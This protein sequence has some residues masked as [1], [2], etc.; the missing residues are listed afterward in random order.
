MIDAQSCCGDSSKAGWGAY[1][2]AW[3]GKRSAVDGGTIN[4]L[5]VVANSGNSQ[6]EASVTEALREIDSSLQFCPS[7]SSSSDKSFALSVD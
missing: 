6:V 1:C 3:S 7:G 4:T 5:S 2:G